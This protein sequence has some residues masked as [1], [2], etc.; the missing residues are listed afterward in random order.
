V[1]FLGASV[2]GPHLITHLH[3]TGPDAVALGCALPTRLPRAHATITACQAVGI[4][5]L[6]GGSGFGSDGRFARLLG[7]DG[8]APS[9]DAAA[10]HLAAGRLP[11]FPEP[12][13]TLAHLAD[14]EYTQVARGR[15]ALITGTMARLAK[16]GPLVASYSDR[17]L[18]ATAD[19]LGHIID[20]LAAALY[21][22]DVPLFTDFVT[23]TCDVLR[24]RDVPVASVALGLRILHDEMPEF[25]RARRLLADGVQAARGHDAGGIPEGGPGPGAGNGH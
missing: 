25:P 5:V 14:E 4:P 3:Q 16:S 6:A 11:S 22:D 12:F 7:A 9:A 15:A 10:D 18:E 1:D 21:V 24:A 13:D 2:P 17:Q 23:W 19:D 8:W 20:F